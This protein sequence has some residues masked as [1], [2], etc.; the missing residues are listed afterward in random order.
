MDHVT[1]RVA[2]TP[3]DY[4][5]LQEAQ[6]RAW[7]I[8]DD[9]AILPVA[10]MAS[11]RHHGG[12]VAGAFL[13]DGSAV[14][15][16]FGFLGRIDGRLCL[17]SQ[18]TGVV[19]G[20]QSRG[21]GLR[22]KEAQRRF[23]RVQGIGL[24]AW[25]FDPMQAGN[26]HFNLQKLGASCRRFVSD[27]YGPRTD[28]LNSGV[29]TDRIIAEWEVDA[30]PRTEI[31]A[32]EIHVLPRLIGSE[33]S[34]DEPR[35]LLEIPAAITALRGGDPASAEAWRVAVGREMSRSFEAGY[36]AVG[37]VRGRADPRCFYVLDRFNDPPRP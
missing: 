12:F 34:G 28:S 26:A 8:V 6:R 5:R 4:R 23:C 37:F 9:T 30:G 22:L 15:V 3:A 2:E 31:S 35:L 11:A 16:S 27:M 18:L 25:A 10:T 17:Y 32:E 14:G 36:R 1:V 7:G 24:V 29:P 33:V 13:C 21:L 20:Y 19:P